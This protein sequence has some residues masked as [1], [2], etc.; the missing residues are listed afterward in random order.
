MTQLKED[1]LSND[2]PVPG[3]NFFCF[4][5]V[6]PE[7]TLR[8]KEFYL[9]KNF[10]QNT[11]SDPL[12]LK[13]ILDKLEN[14]QE[15]SYEDVEDLYESY[16]IAHG[17]EICKKF[18]ED[19][20][21]QTS[22]RGI[23]IRGSYDTLKEA[24]IRSEVLKRKDPNFDTWIGQIGYWCPMEPHANGNENLEQEF[25]EPVLNQLYS[26]K[27]E[28]TVE[29]E[30]VFDPLVQA[31]MEKKEAARREE[32]LNQLVKIHNDN[33][34]SGRDQFQRDVQSK[35]DQ[36]AKET[37]KKKEEQLKLRE[38][39]EAKKK[40]TDDGKKKKLK[41]KK[42]KVDKESE[43]SLP[44]T[45][46]ELIEHLRKTG[47]N[48]VKNKDVTVQKESSSTSTSNHDNND[49]KET[50]DENVPKENPHDKIKELRQI[51]DDKER[52]LQSTK[53]DTDDSGRV[54]LNN[55]MMF[56]DK[57]QDIFDGPDSDPWMQRKKEAEDNKLDD[58]IQ[59]VL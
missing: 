51:L 42:K 55:N 53:K 5:C 52:S 44:K 47:E 45:K 25:S 20:D 46:T 30:T 37:E 49:N 56:E 29:K 9:I 35:K 1:F 23:K 6:W 38:K 18:D 57:G 36:A 13:T 33:L 10:L 59:K 58:V 7:K 34:E 54:N 4:S 21:F 43:K 12:H 50:V 39:E 16:V 31:E 27:K 3:Q 19:N 48:V 32:E 11:L 17:D 15:I 22:T 2:P 8:R 14:D 26:K 41:K 28:N 40:V 24:R